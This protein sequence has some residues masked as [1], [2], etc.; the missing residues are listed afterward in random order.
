MSSAS[1]SA[2]PRDIES[3]AEIEQSLRFPR[4]TA[5]DAWLLGNLLCNRLRD[6]DNP[7]VVNITLANC[8]QL[9]FHACS[10]PGTQPDNDIWVARKRKTVL[11]W[12][13]STWYMHN[14]LGGD[15]AKFQAKYMLGETA[16]DYAI[17]G[18]G[19]PIR[20]TGVEGLV[21]VIVVS[22][23]AQDQDHQIIVEQVTQFI[24]E[25]SS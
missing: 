19:F 7:A 25:Y 20:V 17:H 6:F 23:L 2:P 3:I 15:E 16:G 11:R 14:K 5:D 4:F 9:L 24:K 21:G 18:G 12:G 10:R 22:G 8:N 1:L 13:F